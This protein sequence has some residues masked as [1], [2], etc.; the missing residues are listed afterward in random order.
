MLSIASFVF[1]YYTIWALFLVRLFS[2]Q[3]VP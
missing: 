3:P 2:F 1:V